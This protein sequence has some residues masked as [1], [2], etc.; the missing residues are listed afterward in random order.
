MEDFGKPN[1]FFSLCVEDISKQI[2][3]MRE[4]DD[5]KQLLLQQASIG[6]FLFTDEDIQRSIKHI[7][8]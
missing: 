7:L 2:T 4:R 3:F 5:S 6:V 8:Y 1:R